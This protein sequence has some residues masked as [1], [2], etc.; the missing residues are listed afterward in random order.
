MLLCRH[1]TC[2]DLGELF[3]WILFPLFS[4]KRW[5]LNGAHEVSIHRSINDVRLIPAVVSLYR[6][7]NKPP[8]FP[9]LY[10]Y[11]KAAEEFMATE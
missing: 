5:F 7:Q 6:S 9:V 4:W 1:K 3:R 8:S 10:N 2:E 11:T